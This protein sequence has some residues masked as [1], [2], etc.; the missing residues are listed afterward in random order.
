MNGAV[1]SIDQQPFTSISDVRICGVY[2]PLC[3]TCFYC[4]WPRIG[5][6]D[7]DSTNTVRLYDDG[8]N[9]DLIAGDNIWTVYVHFPGWPYI[10]IR[11]KYAV[12]W[13]LPTNSGGNDNESLNDEH[14]IWITQNTIS[15]SVSNIFGVMGQHQITDLVVVDVEDETSTLVS[16]YNLKQNYPNP[17]NP[18]TTI[19]YSISEAGY[20]NLNMYNVLGEKIAV[21][22]D[23]FKSTGDYVIKFNASNLSAG[24]YFYSLSVNGFTKTKK[25]VLTR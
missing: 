9:G 3:G 8:S 12:N 20:V 23:E 24:I 22:V 14:R 6:P 17:F 21:L 25:M 7:E 2:N 4:C 16:S 15:A 5:W 13:G 10:I 18:S 11:Y 1:S 19:R